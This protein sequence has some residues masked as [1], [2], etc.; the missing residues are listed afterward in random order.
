M[1]YSIGAGGGETLAEY[2]IE[3]GFGMLP[4][5]IVP[6]AGSGIYR[7]MAAAIVGGMRS[8][9][10]TGRS[11]LTCPRATTSGPTPHGC[12]GANFLCTLALPGADA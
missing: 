9:A 3:K 10:E 7:G 12:S 8:A 6:G 5:L 1:D 4:L 2:I 11:W